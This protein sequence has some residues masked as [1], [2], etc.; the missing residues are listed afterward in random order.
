MSIDLSKLQETV[1]FGAGSEIL[2]SEAYKKA[3]KLDFA[4]G[5]VSNILESLPSLIEASVISDTFIEEKVADK[6]AQNKAKAARNA[7]SKACAVVAEL[8]DSATS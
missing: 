3:A 7:A 2:T 6:D 4:M 5:A 1:K 8:V